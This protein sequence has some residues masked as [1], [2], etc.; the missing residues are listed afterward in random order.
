MFLG[1]LER[2]SKALNRKVTSE[3]V[4]AHL[5]TMYNLKALDELEP[6]PFPNENSDFSLPESEFHFPIKH[7]TSDDENEAAV[8][9]TK[10]ESESSKYQSKRTRGSLSTE[11]PANTPPSSS[12]QSTKRRRI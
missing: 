6:L 4:W 11:S 8:K 12:Q 7:K 1:I 5:K 2:L 9:S 10:S 3:Q